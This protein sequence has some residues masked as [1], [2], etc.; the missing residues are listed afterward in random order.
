M[1]IPVNIKWLV[2][3]LTA[4]TMAACSTDEKKQEE[5]NRNSLPQL[6]NQIQR[7]SKLYTTEVKAHKIITYYD[8]KSISGSVLGMKINTELPMSGRKIAIPLDA[9]L[10]AY[11]DLS[12]FNEFNVSLNGDK[13]EIMLPEPGVEL[14]S[15]KVDHKNIRHHVDLL[16]GRFSDEELTRIENNGRNAIIEEMGRME[17][18]EKAQ[19]SATKTLMPIIE[20]CGFDCQNVT[21][22][23]GPITKKMDIRT[24]LENTAIENGK[25]IVR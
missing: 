6:I 13:M 20:K 17:I 19:Q 4:A 1:I 7:C 16:R 14:T 11:I 2:T 10:K 3:V 12:N 9:T 21:I 18:M 24:L 25:Q 8:N 15:S 5:I 23:Y 22:T